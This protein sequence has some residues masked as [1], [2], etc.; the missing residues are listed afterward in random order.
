MS[1]NDEHT[2]SGGVAAQIGFG[3]QNRVAAWM[4]VQILAER[5]V[6]PL[7]RLNT[8]V[9]FDYI[10]CETGQPID[11][12]LLGTSE[13]GHAF[14][15]VKHTVTKSRGAG[16]ALGSAI[17][18]FVRQFLSYR[19]HVRGQLPWERQLDPKVDRLVLVT[20]SKSSAPIKQH[21]PRVLLQLRDLPRNG[22]I[23]VAATNREEEEILAVVRGHIARVWRESTGQDLAEEEELELLKLLWVETLDV[24]ED[25]AGEREAKDLLRAVVLNDPGQADA[26]WS[27]L[28]TACDGYASRQ[29]GADRLSL[30]Q[31]L[32]TAGIRVKAPSSYR[33]DIE[34]LRAQSEQTLRALQELS[35]I[36]VGEREVKIQRPSTQSLRSALE[37]TPV[38]VVGEPGA[39]KSGAM[40][41][42]A[43]ALLQ[44]DKDVVFLAVD[45]LEAR[46]LNALRQELNLEHDLLEVPKNWQDEGPAFLAIDALDAARSEASAQT[47][48]DL[49]SL[50]LRLPQH[51]RV[52]ASIR[53]FDLRHHTR[54]QHL[55]AAN[56]SLGVVPRTPK[57]LTAR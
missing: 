55:V 18:Q 13:A 9:T 57:A 26:A 24:E 41:D 46:S 40:H 51:W 48:Y 1:V 5:D 30:Y 19:G 20:S 2:S 43:A 56:L 6:T 45:R 21:L 37:Q 33:K 8:S 47:F 32:L 49:I 50:T 28:I 3:Y 10:R 7:R 42:L 31:H 12:I 34:Q 17:D 14:I 22:R 29:G 52:V 23:D 53:R 35:T 44:E 27:A 16:S 4:C 54:L 25:T 15:N 39:G 11:D 36:R 38:V